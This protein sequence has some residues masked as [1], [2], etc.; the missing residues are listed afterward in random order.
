LA[1][2]CRDFE[3]LRLLIDSLRRVANSIEENCIVSLKACEKISKKKERTYFELWK[4]SLHRSIYEA[5]A[6][7]F[8]GTY[9]ENA[10]REWETHMQGLA[11]LTVEDSIVFDAKLLST[12]H[13]LFFSFDLA[14]MPFRF[15]GLPKEMVSR[16][17][18]PKRSQLTGL[19][20]DGSVVPEVVKRAARELATW[21]RFGGPL[22]H[23][24]VFATRPFNIDELY[25]ISDEP[26][27]CAQRESMECVVLGTRGFRM[28]EP[29]P[30]I[31]ENNVL[32]LKQTKKVDAC[33]IAVS[34]WM[35]KF[36]SWI[37]A[38]TADIEPDKGRY[39]RLTRL[40]NSALSSTEC[41]DYLVMPEL[42]LPAN[43]FMR[44]ARKLR[45]RGISLISGIQYLH[46]KRNRVRHQVWASLSHNALGFPSGYIYRQDKQR[47]AFHEE[48]ELARVGGL[49]MKPQ[50]PWKEQKPPVIR[51]G[52]LNFA[53]L[54]CSELTNIDYRS[55]LRGCIDILFIPEW[56][57]D[58]E[59]FN[60]LIESAAL[61]IHAYIVQCNDRAYGDSRI[62]APFKEGWKRDVL[63]VKG[64]LSDYCVMG[65][66]DI[67][68]LRGFQSSYR[69]PSGPFKPVPDGFSLCGERKMLP[70]HQP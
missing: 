24:I 21:K 18:I 54:V 68:L 53:I 60:S 1:T 19:E 66:V 41:P 55:S 27:N 67:S 49:T 16:R 56:N 46:V 11:A 34:S 52:D 61:D 42:A 28:K 23:G 13:S 58:T 25:L 48:L 7:A 26:R 9:G 47:P 59:T 5:V 50:R 62:R 6:M 32:H 17:G 51:H 35:T 4:V 33:T 44:I 30:F 40:M 31:D 70:L 38:V 57:Q 2:A 12:Q 36:D 22:P 8:P 69:S 43:W 20:V 37:A 15:K 64:G 63:R 29:P 45:G 3:Q 65:V 10:V 14:H 39:G